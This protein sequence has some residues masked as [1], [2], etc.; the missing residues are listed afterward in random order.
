MMSPWPTYVT[1][2]GASRSSVRSV[3]SRMIPVT[4]TSPSTTF[5]GTVGAAHHLV[6]LVGR[7]PGQPSTDPTCACSSCAADS[8]SATSSARDCT[9]EPAGQD[10]RPHCGGRVIIACVSTPTRGAGR[11]ST[12]TGRSQQERALLRVGDAGQRG[13]LVHGGRIGGDLPL[14]R[15]RVLQE[16]GHRGVGP[17]R[18]RQGGE[19]H[20]PHH[21]R[22][23]RQHGQAA[24]V[25]PQPSTNAPPHRSH[26]RPPLPAPA[27][28][29]PIVPPQTPRRAGA[30][31]TTRGASTRPRSARDPGERQPKFRACRRHRHKLSSARSPPGVGSGPGCS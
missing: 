3:G 21:G 11:P 6:H 26:Q 9:R 20:R 29:A 31:T 2:L 27:N 4:R 1:S 5:G 16:P 24:P 14:E 19:H 17:A 13:D 22:D 7:V 30:S 25:P 10:N 12:D 15:A 28:S 8:L 23:Q 18:A